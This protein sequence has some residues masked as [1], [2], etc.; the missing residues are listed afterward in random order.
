MRGNALEQLIRTLHVCVLMAEGIG[1]DGRA[2]RAVSASEGGPHQELQL[3]SL[4]G[5][6][7][8]SLPSLEW[9]AGLGPVKAL[10][11]EQQ[12]AYEARQT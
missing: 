10:A 4:C 7:P 2:S 9:G 1:D 8:R 6:D 5:G 11:R 3:R 12:A